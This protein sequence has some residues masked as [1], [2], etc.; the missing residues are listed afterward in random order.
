MREVRSSDVRILRA[1]GWWK[2]RRKDGEGWVM[3][4]IKLYCSCMNLCK[5]F[6]MMG[7]LLLLTTSSWEGVDLSYHSYRKVQKPWQVKG[8]AGWKG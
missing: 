3:E 2:I 7:S 6:R 1:G 8:I 5:S 4:S